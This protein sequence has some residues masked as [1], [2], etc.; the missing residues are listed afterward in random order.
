VVGPDVFT[1]FLRVVSFV[2][3]E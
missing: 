3:W 2:K 1:S